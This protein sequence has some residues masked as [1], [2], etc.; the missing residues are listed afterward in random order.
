VFPRAIFLNLAGY[1]YIM[2]EELNLQDFE[3]LLDFQEILD[4]IARKD[5][6]HN[7]AKL[8]GKYSP[9]ELSGCIRNSWYNR[10]YPE[11][12]DAQAYRAFLMGNI[13]H[14]LFQKNLDYPDRYKTF[15]DHPILEGIKWVESEKSYMYMLPFEKTNG[16]RIVISGRLDSILY[17]KD[18]NDPIIVDYK[19]AKT[20]KYNM[21]APKDTHVMQLNFYLGCALATYG[22]LV[23][24]D[25]TNL[26]II[27]HTIQYSQSIF[28][29]MVQ[30]A[31]NLD[32]CIRKN[33]VPE[34]SVQ[35]MKKHGYCAYCKHKDKCAEYEM[36]IKN[37]MPK[38]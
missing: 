10:I 35:Q 2:G 22:I 28:D 29:K 14:E 1:D 27:Q 24:I 34:C 8:E 33:K 37:E 17:L 32:D 11:P 38:L 31:I 16:N 21:N 19:T 26:E 36:G 7:H 20:I 3:K 9:T 13:L 12:Y 5:D 23:Y 30:Y 15:K 6:E 18:R 4:K 25:K